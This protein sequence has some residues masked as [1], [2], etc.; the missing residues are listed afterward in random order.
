M[1]TQNNEVIPPSFISR[2]STFKEKLCKSVSDIYYF[3]QP[4]D[5]NVH[6]RGMLLI[7][8]KYM[9]NFPSENCTE[10]TTS[11][12]F[13]ETEINYIVHAALTIRKYL[14]ENHCYNGLNISTEWVKSVVP[15]LLYLFLSVLMRGLEAVDD[16]FDDE[17]GVDSE[18]N[19]DSNFG[20]DENTD[21]ENE[22]TD[23][24]NE[25]DIEVQREDTHS[26]EGPE[27]KAQRRR[28][29]K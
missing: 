22:D 1:C 14:L 15:D 29:S 18:D 25:T 13:R 26:K 11:M 23:S 17:S 21:S 10:T 12:G 7:P 9:H 28:I 2:R 19:E 27:T 8:K 20:N 16:F 5:R 3:H 24:E 4:L 6:E